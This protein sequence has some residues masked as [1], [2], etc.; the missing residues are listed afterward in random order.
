MTR[1]QFFNS[2]KYFHIKPHVLDGRIMFS[3]SSSLIDARK[4]LDDCP[5]LEAEMILRQAV[6]NP[7]L[8]DLIT[9]RA[10]IRWENGYSDSLYMAVLCN[11][12]DTGEMSSKELKPKTDWTAELSK[13]R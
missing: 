9:E 8:M 10:C 6:H 12:K 11:I 2:L 7:D 13:Y 3:G 5:E 4:A 1:E